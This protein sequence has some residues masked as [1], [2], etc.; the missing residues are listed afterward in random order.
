MNKPIFE[1]HAEREFLLRLL[2]PE[3]RRRVQRAMR[4][5]AVTA[6]DA[7]Q[8]LG[9]GRAVLGSVLPITEVSDER[10]FLLTEKAAR[11]MPSGPPGSKSLRM[12]A[13]APCPGL[14]S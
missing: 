1:T 11:G 12:K 7:I 5:R 6:T 2:S 13:A 10:E 14:K 9:I 8:V 3:D 4:K